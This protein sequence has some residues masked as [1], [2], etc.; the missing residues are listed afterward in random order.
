MYLLYHL[1]EELRQD[2]ILLL[3][4]ILF[5]SDKDFLP[6]IS[7]LCSMIGKLLTDPAPEMKIKLS[8]F[9]I[10]LCERLGKYIGV[11]SKSIILSLSNN[12]KHSHNKVRKITIMVILF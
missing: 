7:D 9:I 12:L 8:E 3:Q 5:I 2:L 1:A 4:K 10:K 11:H 6:V